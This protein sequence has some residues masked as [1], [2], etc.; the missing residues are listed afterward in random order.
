MKDSV[1]RTHVIS[2]DSYLSTVLRMKPKLQD[3]TISRRILTGVRR[4]LEEFVCRFNMRI[5]VFL[6]V[7]MNF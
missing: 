5:V 2:F 4:N 7:V 1:V 6:L 3:I